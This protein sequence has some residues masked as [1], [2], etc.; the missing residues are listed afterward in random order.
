[1][2]GTIYQYQN[3]FCF[4]KRVFYLKQTFVL[5]MLFDVILYFY[6]E[7]SMNSLCQ[8]VFLHW[9]WLLMFVMDLCFPVIH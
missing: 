4:Q 9:K 8:I 1:M 5:F 3:V 7:H 2:N 6:Y